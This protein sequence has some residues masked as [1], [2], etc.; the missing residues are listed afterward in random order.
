MASKTYSK[1]FIPLES[2]PDLFTELMHSLGGSLSLS[3]DDVFS[4]DDPELL[5]YIRR[6]V[7][8]LILTFPTT[9]LYED[10]KRIEEEKIRA[11][12]EIPLP[13]D[14]IWFKQTINNACGLYGLLHAV[15]SSPARHLVGKSFLGA[16][17]YIMLK[18]L[19]ICWPPEPGSFLHTLITTSPTLSTSD[20][21]LMLENSESLETAYRTVAIQGDSEVPEDAE[22]EVDYH[23]ICFARSSENN[24]VFQL[25]GDRSGPIDRGVLV[26]QDE[27]MLGEGMLDHIRAF[28]K[29]YEHENMSFNLMALVTADEG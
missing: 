21:A 3:Y 1:H 10:D 2:N 13:S 12:P 20:R 7:N 22:A 4:I 6:P 27:D 19:L 8:A 24:H 25:D 18:S 23:Y 16:V 15:C 9:P 26:S 28:M 14:I 29:R 17:Q 11:S 5:A